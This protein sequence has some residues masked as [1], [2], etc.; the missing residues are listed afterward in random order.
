MSCA[1][2]DGDGGALLW[3]DALCRV[4]RPQVAGYPGFVRVVLNRHAGEM[5][6]LK[7]SE[8]ETLMRTVF[9]CE[10]ALLALYKPD[11]INLASFGNQVP[12]VHWH[13]I[14]RF[15]GDAHFPDPIWAA[16]RRAA[17]EPPVVADAVLAAEI[18]KLLEG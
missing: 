16:P 4:V 10:R 12:H 6:E 9:A 18:R 3:R 8:R 7:P 17:S 13:V 5:T 1:L 15:S 11:K 14:A 2:C